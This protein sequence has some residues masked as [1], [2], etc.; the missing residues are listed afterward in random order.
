VKHGPSETLLDDLSATV[1]WFDA[2]VAETNNGFQD[3]VLARAQLD[4]LSDEVMLLVGML[5]GI[6]RYRFERDPELPVA[7]KAAKHVVAGPQ[8][9]EASV[10]VPT[11]PVATQ[12]APGEVKPA[13]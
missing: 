7:W 2:S 10:E 9:P 4:T 3:H 8:A 12:P 5:D 6:N 13:A 1:D 11:T